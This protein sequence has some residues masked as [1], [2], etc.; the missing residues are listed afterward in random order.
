[1][2]LRDMVRFGV[3]EVLKVPLRVHAQI[4]NGNIP[5]LAWSITTDQPEASNDLTVG[6]TI[7]F[8]KISQQACNEP[9]N[10]R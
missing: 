3:H 10:M 4:A 9:T 8:P 2:L 7:G 6:T 5:A 1:M